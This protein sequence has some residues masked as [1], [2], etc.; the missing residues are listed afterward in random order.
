MY[1]YRVNHCKMF[2]IITT[3]TH[4]NIEMAKAKGMNLVQQEICLAKCGLIHKATVVE[5]ETVLIIR[6][7]KV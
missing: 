3:I 4:R 2:Y 1:I 7:Y 6:L 5:I